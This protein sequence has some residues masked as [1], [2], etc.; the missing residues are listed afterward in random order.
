MLGLVR[1]CDLFQIIAPS[2]MNPELKAG[3]KAAPFHD[4]SVRKCDFEAAC[5]FRLRRRVFL[6]PVG[7]LLVCR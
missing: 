7:G 4:K 1:A 3:H 5:L 6:Q 2:T